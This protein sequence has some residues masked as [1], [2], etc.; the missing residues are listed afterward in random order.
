M[1]STKVQPMDRDE[2]RHRVEICLEHI[3]PEQVL[4]HYDFT[5]VGRRSSRKGGQ[6]IDGVCPF[7]RTITLSLSMH[8]T[9]GYWFCRSAVCGVKGD[10]LRFIELKE[11]CTPELAYEF[12]CELADIEPQ[13]INPLTM[14]LSSLEGIGR[15]AKT[16]EEK[17]AQEILPWPMSYEVL[18]HPYLVKKR[19]VDPSV[20]QG[21]KSGAIRLDPFYKYRACIPLVQNGNLY[22]IYSRAISSQKAWMKV[23][24][25][26]SSRVQSLYPK[27]HYKGNTLTSRLLFGIDEVRGKFDTVIVVEA[28]I[29]VLRLRT[30]GIHNAVAMLKSSLSTAQVNILMESFEKVVI[31]NDNDVREDLD[32]G[33]MINPGMK[34]AWD[35]YKK[36]KEYVEVGVMY[37]PPNIDPADLESSEEFE[38]LL[39][40]TKW[41]QADVQ[42]RLA[43]KEMMQ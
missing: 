41:S 39:K 18:A 38:Y 8:S 30:M 31:C 6:E 11:D 7:H 43:V 42:A 1:G 15:R 29:S 9:S 19:Q 13:E 37:M 26:E 27:H 24:P 23:H 36:L 33:K 28:I 32:S 16:T 22:S 10:L 21:V 34:A 25:H 17:D 2:R 12:L 4:Q 14:M 20:L 5:F 40:K 3:D 35:N